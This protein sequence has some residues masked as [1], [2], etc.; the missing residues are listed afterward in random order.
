LWSRDGCERAQCC[1]SC[2]RERVRVERVAQRQRA[3]LPGCCWA[4]QGSRCACVCGS[5]AGQRE[6]CCELQRAERELCC[7][8]QWRHVWVH[9][10]NCCW[11]WI[12]IVWREFTCP[13]WWQRG[14]VDGLDQREQCCRALW[15]RCR[16]RCFRCSFLWCS[17]RRLVACSELQC[18]DGFIREPVGSCRLW[19]LVG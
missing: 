13:F 9:F 14:F 10:C 12:C 17:G 18:C 19:S 15:V 3:C 5:A 6:W 11:R 7:R 1:W 2:G 16:R 4:R 8:Q